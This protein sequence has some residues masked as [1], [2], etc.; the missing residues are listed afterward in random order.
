M[1]IFIFLIYEEK[2][3]SSLNSCF[4]STN[5][6]AILDSIAALVTKNLD[7]I[8]NNCQSSGYPL[9]QVSKQPFFT[10]SRF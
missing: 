5:S 3:V 4:N 7:G 1:F 6:F 2:M 9:D 10:A 8:K